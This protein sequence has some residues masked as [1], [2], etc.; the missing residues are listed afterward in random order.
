MGEENLAELNC[1]WDRENRETT[2]ARTDDGLIVNVFHEDGLYSYPG[3]EDVSV[4]KDRVD[5]SWNLTTGELSATRTA[6]LNVFDDPGGYRLAEVH[7][8]TGKPP[9]AAINLKPEIRAEVEAVGKALSKVADFDSD[10]GICTA[11]NLAI[12]T[13]RNPENIASDGKKGQGI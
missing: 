1:L 10:T 11:A 13:L 8:E 3:F 6:Y 7:P 5:A 9:G 12:S 2:V 4:G